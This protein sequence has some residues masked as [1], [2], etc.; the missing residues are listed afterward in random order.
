MA[1]TRSSRSKTPVKKKRTPTKKKTPAKKSDAKKA[2]S[3][4]GSS[5]AGFGPT[6]DQML[7][8]NTFCQGFYGFAFFGFGQPHHDKF[9]GKDAVAKYGEAGPLCTAMPTWM[10][11]MNMLCTYSHS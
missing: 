10:G 9:F 11:V 8:V 1:R 6:A 3:K 4:N 7:L 5:A 2:A